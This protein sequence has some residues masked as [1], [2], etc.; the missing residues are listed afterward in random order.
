MKQRVLD[1]FVTLKR[2]KTSEDTK[3][4]KPEEE[5]IIKKKPQNENQKVENKIKLPKETIENH[6]SNLPK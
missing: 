1:N 4:E 5:K 2:K 6:P 3:N